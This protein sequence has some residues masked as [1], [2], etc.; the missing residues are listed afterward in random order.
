MV[1]NKVEVLEEWNKNKRPLTYDVIF[2]PNTTIPTTYFPLIKFYGLK[3]SRILVLLPKIVHITLRPHTCGMVFTTLTIQL[4][5]ETQFFVWACLLIEVQKYTCLRNCIHVVERHLLLPYWIQTWD[6]TYFI[7]Y[8]RKTYT[9]AIAWGGGLIC[10]PCLK[11]GC[12]NH[13]GW[14]GQVTQEVRERTDIHTYK[15]LA[16]KLE[17]NRYLRRP[18][19]RRQEKIKRVLTFAWKGVDRI[20][21]AHWTFDSIKCEDLTIWATTCFSRCG[22]IRPLT[23]I[24][25]NAMTAIPM[26]GSL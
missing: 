15:L 7:C 17:G 8:F 22:Y 1:A 11:L 10:T 13:G 9:T 18:R 12:S 21:L 5:S 23:G 2:S 16:G 26:A 4:T 19:S 14:N 24:A 25:P 20:T 6:F 3:L